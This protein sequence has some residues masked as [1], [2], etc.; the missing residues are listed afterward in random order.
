MQPCTIRRWAAHQRRSSSIGEGKPRCGRDRF[1]LLTG[2]TTRN[3]SS[4]GPTGT[5]SLTSLRQASTSTCARMRAKP[6]SRRWQVGHQCA[7][8]PSCLPA[9][10]HPGAHPCSVVQPARGANGA[11]VASPQRYRIAPSPGPAAVQRSQTAALGG[12]C[13]GDAKNCIEALSDLAGRRAG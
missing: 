1:D 8:P 7:L 6:S 12:R 13:L 11:R 9:F 3:F 5:G 2:S 10:S 4:A